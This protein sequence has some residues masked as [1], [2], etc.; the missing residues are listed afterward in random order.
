MVEARRQPSRSGSLAPK[1]RMSEDRAGVGEEHRRGVLE[2]DVGAVDREEGGEPG[3]RDEPEHEHEAGS[4]GGAVEQ[5]LGLLVG[6][7]VV[8]GCAEPEERRRASA[9]SAATFHTRS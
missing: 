5:R 2:A 6:H 1:M 7:R 9:V 4:E 3:E 8:G